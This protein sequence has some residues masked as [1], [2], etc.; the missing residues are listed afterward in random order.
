MKEKLERTPQEY[1]GLHKKTIK[2]F[3]LPDLMRW[4]RFDEVEEKDNFLEVYNLPTLN[5]E[6]VESLKSLITSK[7]IKI[8][9]K[10][11]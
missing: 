7:E 2:G 3:I 1:K 5:Y 6:E 4:K 11:L 10:V 8:V 9:T